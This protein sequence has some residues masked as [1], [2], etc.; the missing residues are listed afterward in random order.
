MTDQRDQGDGNQ[1]NGNRNNE[2]GLNDLGPEQLG[3]EPEEVVLERR[4][5]RRL[6]QQQAGDWP[7]VRRLVGLII[8]VGAFVLGW[9]M[10]AERSAEVIR[11]SERSKA[12][13][14]PLSGAIADTTGETSEV[15][16]VDSTPQD[17]HDHGDANVLGRVVSPVRME[18]AI[19]D[20]REANTIADCTKGQDAFRQIDLNA[21]TIAAGQATLETVFAPVVSSNRTVNTELSSGR[22]KRT[23]QMQNVR[24]LDAKGQELRLHA[25]P[26]TQDG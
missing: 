26:R 2:R 12:V 5:D 10:L 1:G 6:A 15:I 21:G 4:I 25:A 16:Q 9:R 7:W 24:I 20:S 13:V 18:R 17:T 14:P 22:A 11:L 8:I 23:L 3:P 19:L